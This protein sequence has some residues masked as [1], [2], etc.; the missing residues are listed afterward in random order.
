MNQIQKT[1]AAA[2]ALA[3][4]LVGATLVSAPMALADSHQVVASAHQWS[5]HFHRVAADLRSVR[6]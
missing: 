5:G 4:T 2:I 1:T 6:V 3:I